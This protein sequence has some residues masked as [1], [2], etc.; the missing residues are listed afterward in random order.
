MLI[1]GCLSDLPQGF[2]LAGVEILRREQRQALMGTL[3]ISR[4]ELSAPLT[5]VI[6]AIEPSWIG[7]PVLGGLELT[8]AERIVIAD[9]G[10]REALVD[11]QTR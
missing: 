9:S 7:G 4:E 3:L 2:D 11:P 6:D 5:G 10:S 8:F 1:H